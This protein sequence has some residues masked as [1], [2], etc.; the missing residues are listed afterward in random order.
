MLELRDLS[1]AYGAVKAVNG[2]SLKVEPGSIHGLIG[3]NGAGKT[4]T[5][6]LVSG[7]RKP[8][9]GQILYKGDDVTTRSVSWKRHQGIS[10]SFQR[11]TVFPEMTVADQLD[12]AARAVKDD[13]LDHIVEELDLGRVL[14][15]PCSRIAYGEQR[16]VDIALALL[17]NPELVLLDEPAAGLSRDESLVLADHLAL[18]ARD[19]GATVVIV[20]HHLEVV[21]R[22]CSHLTVL[23]QG[24][25]IAD[26]APDQVRKDPRVMEAYLG[27]SVS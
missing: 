27:R 17:G 13:G 5:I 20:E 26:G 19:R 23:E 7:K 4:T 3:P 1:F 14:E 18:L 11:I 2:V 22:I 15:L 12:L 24:S 6:D 10:R 16:R 21:F 25:V 9:S 8:T